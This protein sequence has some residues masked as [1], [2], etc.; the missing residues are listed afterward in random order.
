MIKYLNLGRFLASAGVAAV[1]DVLGDLSQGL[2]ALS[3]WIDPVGGY[4]ALVTPMMEKVDRA[5]DMTWGPEDFAFA[6]EV[7]ERSASTREDGPQ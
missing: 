5:L 4:V 1:A 7:I 6:A 2:D 3:D